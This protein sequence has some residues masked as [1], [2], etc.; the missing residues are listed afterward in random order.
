MNIVSGY[1]ASIR[2]IH[3]QVKL[4]PRFLSQRK[5]GTCPSWLKALLHKEED[6]CQAEV[7][8]QR[9]AGII[10]EDAETCDLMEV[11]YVTM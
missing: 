3:P 5:S 1:L 7:W 8:Q 11:A 6:G 9:K 2:V 4:P 10:P